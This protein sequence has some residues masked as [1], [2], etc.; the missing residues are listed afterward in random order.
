[1][2][3]LN[4]YTGLKQWGWYMHNYS[5]IIEMVKTK[6]PVK[7]LEIGTFDGI[8]ACM[9]LD[10]L[11][12]HEDSE[13]IT[14]DPYMP[15]LTTPQVNASTEQTALSNFNI[16]GRKITQHK[17][18]SLEYFFNHSPIAEFDFIYIDGSHLAGDV[19][20]DALFSIKAI[21]KGGIIAFD[22]YLWQMPNII[23]PK[24]AIDAFELI[25]KPNLVLLHSDWQRWYR[26]V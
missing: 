5:H 12:P 6:N 22:D 20:L 2:E 7:V 18:T 1:M 3:N 26:V 17:C 11:F 9:M 13:V 14:I 15:D 21:K 25:F 4:K 24:S 19:M 23:G 16:S 8:S 10:E